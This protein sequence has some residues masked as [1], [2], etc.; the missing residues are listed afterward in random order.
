LERG[1]PVLTVGGAGGKRDATAV[2]VTDLG[3]SGYDPLLKV[4]RRDLRREHGIAVQAG[5]PLG[6]P[7]VVSAEKPVFPWADGGVCETKEEGSSLAMDCASGFGAATFVTGVFGFAAAGEVVRR[8]ALE[9]SVPA[10]SFQKASK[11]PAA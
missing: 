1:I 6:I 5:Q 9:E 10:P 8:I 4:V 11:E 3:V 7:C 2:R